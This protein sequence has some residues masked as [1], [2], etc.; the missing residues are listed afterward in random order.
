MIIIAGHDLVDVENRTHTSQPS[1]TWS[2][3]PARP[4]GASTS[5][6]RPTR[7]IPSGVGSGQGCSY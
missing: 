3:V 6:S 1:L 5:P 2:R 7:L 4:T